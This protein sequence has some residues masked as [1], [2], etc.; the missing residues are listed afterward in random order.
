[1]SEAARQNQACWP[2]VG[3]WCAAP[4]SYTSQPGPSPAGF[5]STPFDLGA[6]LAVRHLAERYGKQPARVLN[7]VMGSKG[8]V[9]GG[10]IARW[11]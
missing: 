6:L 5:D 2:V 4:F 8:G 10:T 3:R 7:V 11:A 9:S 1:M